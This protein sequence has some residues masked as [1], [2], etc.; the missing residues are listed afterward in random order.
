[1]VAAA[2]QAAL[3][4][5]SKFDFQYDWT[6][7]SFRPA[8]STNELVR[9]IHEFS[10]DHPDFQL[11][12]EQLRDPNTL[13]F[14]HATHFADS[15]KMLLDGKKLECQSCHQPGAGGVYYQTPNYEKNCRSCHGLQFDPENP[16]LT[17]PHG[18]S[19]FV[20]SFLHSL[21]QQ[22]TAF[23][24]R[25]KA[26][27]D[28]A[29]VK[30]FVRGRLAALRELYG[31]GEQLE[32]AVFF[33]SERKGPA[34]GIG[35]VPKE[36][37]SLFPGCAYCHEVKTTSDVPAVTPPV[38]PER[39]LNRGRFDHSRHTALN[40]NTCHQATASTTAA[41]ILLPVK[42]TCASC[43]QPQGA[44]RSDCFEC[45]SYHHLRDRNVQTAAIKTSL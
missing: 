23:A 11:H 9:V 17:V 45:H 8:R 39:W 43:H 12:I 35:S 29:Q 25:E 13:R 41:D 20:H 22:L 24:R 16:K 21:P 6:R 14:S 2:A 5:A 36:G 1:M 31:S 28:E 4:P 37:R 30:E 34:T 33:N 15:P 32:Q 42:S 3:L 27:R 10:T 40:C 44:A 19:Q 26:M 18:N 38:M 7:R